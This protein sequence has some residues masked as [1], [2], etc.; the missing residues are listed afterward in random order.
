MLRMVPDILVDPNSFFERE[1]K[2]P[3]WIWPIGIVVLAAMVGILGSIPILQA[4]LA[5]LPPEA[6]ALSSLFYVFSIL[7]G[8]LGTILF[9]LLYAGSFHVISAVAF[10]G[11][12]TF[13]STMKLTGWGFLPHVFSG[14]ISASVN[15]YVFWNATFPSNPAEIASFVAS[16]RSQGIFYVS[17]LLGMAFLLWSTFLWIFAMRHGR[18]LTMRE[19]AITV[20][21]PVL[22]SLLFQLYSL[23]GGL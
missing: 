7:G 1:S 5:N 19:A 10:D 20:A 17:Q 18:D 3:G 11:N 4:T 12:G 9:W 21:I 15:F 2:N 22:L 6:G 16:L 14:L 13:S 23:I 8:L